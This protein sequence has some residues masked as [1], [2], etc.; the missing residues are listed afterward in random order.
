MWYFRVLNCASEK[1]LSSLTRGRLRG[2]VT[3]G[4]AGAARCTG[5]FAARIRYIARSEH[6]YCPSSRRVATTSAGERSKKRPQPRVS[7][8]R[9]RSVSHRA[10]AGVGGGAAGAREPS[11]DDGRRSPAARPAPGTPTPRGP[12]MRAS[13][14]PSAILRVV[15]VQSQ[16][17]GYSSLHIQMSLPRGRT[18]VGLVPA[19]S[20]AGRA[21]GRAWGYAT[22]RAGLL[23]MESSNKVPSVDFGAVQT[24]RDQAV[25][26]AICR[27]RGA[28]TS[29]GA[30]RR[31]ADENR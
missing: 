31:S 13:A 22:A 8:T 12:A 24:S 20:I 19:N 9:S 18:R 30:R 10:R 7:R 16:Q 25:A 3:P 29:D 27:P 2:R 4:S 5:W 26:K 14:P 23:T 15:E 21:R 17:P 1:G 28:A 11:S 6:R